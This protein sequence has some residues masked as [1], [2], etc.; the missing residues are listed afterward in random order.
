MNC[1]GKLILRLGFGGFLLVHG[2]GKVKQLIA[3]DEIQFPDPLGISPLFSLT[4]VAFAEFLCSIFVIIGLKTR[5]ATIPIIVTM[6]VAAFVFHWND[7][8][9][10]KEFPLL[11]AIGFTSLL[12]LGS[13]RFSIDGV[14]SEKD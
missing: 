13:G 1:I 6:L 14:I 2:I 12:F 9:H 7:P 10:N 4:L 3:G 8:F 11:F 5:L